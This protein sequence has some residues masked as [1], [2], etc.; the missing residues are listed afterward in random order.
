MGVVEEMC[1][2]G[3]VARSSRVES[4]VDIRVVLAG[5]RI[6]CTVIKIILIRVDI[7]P[8]HGTKA[9]LWGQFEVDFGAVL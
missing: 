1:T 8:S 2:V 4:L 9:L 5:S 6:N 3:G 7:R